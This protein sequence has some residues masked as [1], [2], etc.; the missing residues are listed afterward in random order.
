M[1]YLPL[2][3]VNILKIRYI[4]NNDY[5]LDSFLV[6]L[7]QKGKGNI[8]SSEDHVQLE[9]FR[10]KYPLLIFVCG[11]GI[12]SK[13][14]GD[15]SNLE[16]IEQVKSDA[17]SFIYN[18]NEENGNFLFVRRSQLECIVSVLANKKMT[19]FP[20]MLF[21]E[22]EFESNFLQIEYAVRLLQQE[23]SWAKLF[24]PSGYSAVIAERIYKKTRIYVLVAVL[25]FL[26]A[27]AFANS[28]LSEEYASVNFEVQK[29][30]RET[31]K[32]ND[33][34]KSIIKEYR[35]FKEGYIWPVSYIC[36][37]IAASLPEQIVLN[38][39]QLYPPQKARDKKQPPEF[40]KDTAYIEGH[41]LTH[42][43]IAVFIANMHSSVPLKSITLDYI[44]QDA[45]TGK[46]NFRI[47]VIL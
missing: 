30:D 31:G 20:I 36:D 42:D 18:G 24:R 23:I 29:L 26:I 1:E 33:I 15:A 41:S 8:L 25:V 10:T 27:N 7:N 14:T 3:K 4:S 37:C 2:R 44:K 32:K 17:S 12:I 5:N 34:Q 45:K 43:A 19:L 38:L 22:N 46:F 9:S 28:I 11:Y 16:I 47:S 6:A 35:A 39:I 40:I 13:N 21:N